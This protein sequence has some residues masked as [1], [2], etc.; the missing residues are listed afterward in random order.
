MNRYKAV[1]PP[2]LQLR[3]EESKHASVLKLLLLLPCYSFFA[4]LY[5][6][7]RLYHK[8]CIFPIKYNPCKRN[9]NSKKAKNTKEMIKAENQLNGCRLTIVSLLSEPTEMIP[10]GTPIISSITEI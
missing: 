9:I 3:P 7:G 1:K 10:T 8:K 6:L 2:L 5:L 4:H